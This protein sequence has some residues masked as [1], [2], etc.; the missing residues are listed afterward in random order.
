VP[1]LS[2]VCLSFCVFVSGSESW[3]S[4]RL[5]FLLV[6]VYVC[7]VCFPGVLRCPC[8]SNVCTSLAVSFPLLGLQRLINRTKLRLALTLRLLAKLANSPNAS[9]PR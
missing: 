8:F 5:L 1:A 4:V 6:F 2:T 7:V 9:L 3:V